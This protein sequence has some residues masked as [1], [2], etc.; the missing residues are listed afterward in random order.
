MAILK[1]IEILANSKI[2]WEDATK[3]AVSHASKTVKNI[4]SVYVKEQS[5]VV[6]NGEVAEFRVNVKI[7]F[8]VNN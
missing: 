8:S 2:S 6:E 5:A 1:V 7:T 4:A 3:N